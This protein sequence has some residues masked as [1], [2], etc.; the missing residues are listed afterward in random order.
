MELDFGGY[1]KEYAVDAAA[2]SLTGSGISAGMVDLGGDLKALGPHTDGTPWQV[3]IP[4]STRSR[5]LQLPP[6]H[7]H[8]ARL[9]V[10][11]DYERYMTID[12]KRYSHILNPKTGWPIESFSAVTVIASECLI[13]GSCSTVCYA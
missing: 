10:S 1:V 3:G 8:M 11:G 13:A 5:K 2:S 9:P 12:G 7:F 4:S 6:Q